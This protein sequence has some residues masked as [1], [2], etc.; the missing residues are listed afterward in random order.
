MWARS[1]GGSNDREEE[2]EEEAIKSGWL[3]RGASADV[4]LL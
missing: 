1:A 4:I 2:E 3:L